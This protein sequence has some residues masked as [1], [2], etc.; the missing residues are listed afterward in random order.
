[1]L[2]DVTVLVKIQEEGENRVPI[3]RTPVGILINLSQAQFKYVR[4]YL[5]ECI[6]PLF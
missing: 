3:F 1:M 5:F 2:M 4:H 6:M